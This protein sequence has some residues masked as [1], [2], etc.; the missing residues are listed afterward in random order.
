MDF[1]VNWQPGPDEV[2]RAAYLGAKRQ[3]RVHLVLPAVMVA[4]GLLYLRVGIIPLS[5]GLFAGA[6]VVPLALRWAVRRAVRR[7]LGYLRRPAIIH[8]T[9]DGYEARTDQITV[10]MRWSMFDRIDS[11]PD[12]W[13]LFVNKRF[14]ACLPKRVFDDEQRRQLESL[15]AARQKT[16]A[17]DGTR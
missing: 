10:A 5:I 12:F 11:T 6:A 1:T 9:S 8:V 13:L 14:A 16:A 17:D 3:S 7:R 4:V 15:F 2:M